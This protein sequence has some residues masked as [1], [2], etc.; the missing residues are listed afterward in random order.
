MPDQ[1]EDSL[2]PEGGTLDGQ[3][4][5]LGLASAVLFALGLL[6][7]ESIGEL[8]LDVD[9]K[10]FFLSYLL[11]TIPRFGTPTLTI[12]LGAA[13][14]EG[15]LD[16]VE[17]YELDD[18]IG[19]LGYVF[20]FIAFGWYLSEVAEDPGSPRSLTVAAVLGAFVQAVFEGFAFLVFES[21][22]TPGDA[23]LSVLGNTV[24]HGVLLG[25][26]PV[27]VLLPSL[28]ARVDTRLL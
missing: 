20:G 10:P 4:V 14:G 13:V 6:V 7:S 27:V 5:A 8:A 3:T 18:P 28:R 17:G 15:V 16:V 1:L 19:F 24:T 26:I 21:G 9:L 22:T 12:G 11:I 2:G 23:A 25:A